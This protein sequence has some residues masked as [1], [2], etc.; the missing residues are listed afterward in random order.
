[1]RKTNDK[2]T[3]RILFGT[4]LV[5]LFSVNLI[6]QDITGSFEHWNISGPT[7]G[8][9]RTIV[10]DP[11]NKNHLFISTF[12]G[13]VHASYDG[14]KTWKLL[15]NFNRSRLILDDL[16]IDPRDSN[17]MY[18][19]GHRHKQSGGFFK[20]TDGG[21]TWREASE[22]SNEAIHAMTQSSQ[23]P[24]MLLVG[25][26]N[27]VWVSRDSGDSWS[28]L[29][30][31]TSPKKL[32]ALAIDP[33]DV[34]TI[35][36]GTWWRAYKTTDGGKNWYLI[37]EG[38]IDDSDIFAIDISSQNPENVIT[39]TCSGIY[40]SFN[41]GEKWHKIKGIPYQSR[42]TRAIL[43]KPGQSETIYAGTTK[44]FWMSSNGGGKWSLTTSD[45]LEINAI[46]VHP[47]EPDKIYIAT[48][49]Y[50]VMV[51]NDGGRNFG[52][53]NGNFSSRF[54]YNITPD[55]EFPNRLYAK[56]INT[57]TGGGFIFVSN[58]F[59]RTWTPSVQNIDTRRTI[60][61]SL[62]QD[63]VN[64]RILYLGTNFGLYESTDRGATWTQIKHPEPNKEQSAERKDVRQEQG[65]KHRK[66]IANLAK[67]NTGAESVLATKINV[68]E[69]TNDGKNG[70]FAGTNKGLYRSYDIAKGWE[71][72]NLGESVRDQV[73]AVHVSLERPNTIWVGTAVSG[74][75]VSHDGGATW[76]RVGME[77][78]LDRVPVSSIMSN[79]GRP[80]DI[81]VG[82]VQ[83]LYLSRDNGI[84][85][86]RRGGDLPM[87][88]YNSIVVN[89]NDSDEIFVASSRERN[90][91]IFQ[92]TDAGW[93]WKRIDRGESLASRRVWSLM[94]NPNN[95]NELLAG[96]HSSGIY[97]IERK[98]NNGLDEPKVES[99]RKLTR[100]RIADTR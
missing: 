37:K 52:S 63:K 57:T 53:N 36:A 92:S 86:S 65:S 67:T 59:G 56:T 81:F 16:I 5:I 82:T 74:V 35:Y 77:I 41:K 25:T 9:V 24:N 50:G 80:N 54:T 49:N 1:M 7:G 71:K 75:L 45:T 76:R 78:I 73:F 3:R 13:Q 99:K 60:S 87:G 19:S 68:L 27:G 17:V 30:S 100:A 64:P 11:K 69:H 90:G 6:G 46:A 84:T 88:N 95:P 61:Y 32:D 98:Q 29:L 58:D 55:I 83:T 48:N 62:I 93:T 26:V 70:Y 4:V 89:P 72:I 8:D 10:I 18:V 14:G 33:K 22:L 91:G 42:R 97:R 20:T 34:N 31:P 38:M 79:P 44:G 28:R 40:Q 51:S 23:E 47:D 85:W 15:V 21:K 39:S 94:L 96:T 43:R 12:D 2:K 66:A